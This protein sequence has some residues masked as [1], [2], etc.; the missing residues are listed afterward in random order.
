MQ[1]STYFRI[2][3][4][5]E[6][7]RLSQ[8]NSKREHK[9][10]ESYP[11]YLFYIIYRKKK[12]SHRT[13]KRQKGNKQTNL[14]YSSTS[15]PSISR[16][17]SL[18]A[19]SVLMGPRLMEAVLNDASFM[20]SSSLICCCMRYSGRVFLS[21]HSFNTYIAEMF[22]CLIGLLKISAQLTGT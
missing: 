2:K 16:K 7:K 9:R 10:G 18:I 13:R 12:L 17:G 8:T 3:L 15:I 1:L 11:V 19:L 6:L 5:R 4:T 20:L 14:P 22:S 21:N